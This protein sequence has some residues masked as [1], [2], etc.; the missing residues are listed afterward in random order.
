MQRPYV[1]QLENNNY[2]ELIWIEASVCIVVCI[3]D[4]QQSCATFQL[5]R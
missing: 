4:Q 1:P 3:R 5:H 2:I